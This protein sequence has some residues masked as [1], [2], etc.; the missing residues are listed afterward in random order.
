M[1]SVLPAA[2]SVDHMTYA[3]M[4]GGWLT[5]S[6]IPLSCIP[7][8]KGEV[9]G[10]DIRIQI[11]TGNSPIPRSTESSTWARFWH[12]NERSLFSIEGVADFEVLRGQQVLIWPAAGAAE[13]DIELALCG[14][15]WATLCHQRGVLPLH[16]SAIVADK[17]IVAFAGHPGAGKSTTAALM[18]AMGYKLVT[19]DILPVS[20]GQKSE[21][22]A[23]PYLRRLK[24]KQDTINDLALTP[25]GAVS[26]TLDTEKYFVSPMFS[27]E[28]DWRRVDQVYLLEQDA[29]AKSASID[30]LDSMDAIRVFLDQTHHFSYLRGSG[31][32]R[33]HLELC[34]RLASKI[35]VYRV[36]RPSSSSIGV[37]LGELICEQIHTNGR[38]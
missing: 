38:S 22:V 32:F 36:R 37:E 15:V 12:W 19:D 3:Y 25:S 16:A 31:R 24:L 11:A 10:A 34:V 28:D 8:L 17:G 20:F 27:A 6:H 4:L 5:R 14:M 29:S 30:K 18:V 7:T 35:S 26:E 23:W 33:E 21:A 2:E 9:S 13:R 1:S